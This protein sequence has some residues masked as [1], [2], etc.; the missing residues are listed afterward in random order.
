LQKEGTTVNSLVSKFRDTV[1]LITASESM[2]NVFRAKQADPDLLHSFEREIREAQRPQAADDQVF[3]GF[4]DEAAADVDGEVNL[5][6]DV[7]PISNISW[8]RGKFSSP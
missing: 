2:V 3:A 4:D 6:P 7:V 1:R 5:D 8:G